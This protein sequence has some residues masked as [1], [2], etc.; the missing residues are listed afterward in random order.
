MSKFWVGVIV[1]A[2][3]G[4]VLFVFSVVENSGCMPWQTAVTTGGGRFSEGD[5][6]TTHCR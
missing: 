5:P 1:V 2:V 3:F 4:F 6:R